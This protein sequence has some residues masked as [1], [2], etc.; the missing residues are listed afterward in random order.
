ML[1]DVMRIGDGT[2]AGAEDVF[3]ERLDAMVAPM[4]LEMGTLRWEEGL[5]TH[6]EHWA[7]HACRFVKTDITEGTDVDVVA[8]AHTLSRQLRG[9]FDAII[10]VS[11]W[12]HL[13][14]PWVAAKE[15]ARV[16]APNGIAFVCTHQTFPLHGYPNDYFRFSAEGLSLIFEDAGLTTLD[17]GYQYRCRIEPPS[18]VT[19]WNRDA[20]SYLNVA[21]AG[22]K[23]PK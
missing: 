17:A 5:P 3:R 15:L 12:E 23:P 7:P 11:V 10:A 22:V 6:H 4:V 18:E 13:K 14:R 8:D 16:L 9:R 21:W 20:E 2:A 1:S 19:R